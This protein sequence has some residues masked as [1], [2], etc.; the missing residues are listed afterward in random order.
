MSV[1]SEQ[2]IDK[3]YTLITQD[4]LISRL[5]ASNI[6][7]VVTSAM[8]TV[9]EYKNLH[10]QEKKQLVLVVLKKVI[11]KQVSDKTTKKQLLSLL[12]T[13]I[14]SVIDNFI[15][16]ARGNTHDALAKPVSV[17]VVKPTFDHLYSTVSKMVKGRTVTPTNI[18]TIGTSVM[19]LVQTY[20]SLN[21]P[22]KKQ[23]VIDILLTLVQD[24]TLNLVPDEHHKQVLHV[25][26]SVLPTAIDMTV[27]FAKGSLYPFFKR[28]K[29]H[30]YN[31][32]GK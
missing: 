24:D 31:C 20:P 26:E 32:I 10:G 30:W 28:I 16:S 8:K 22:E 14:P 29:Q 5:N 21:G 3:L 15:N 4:I 13:T 18:V 19:A 9:Q 2:I 12:D 23:L 27:S 11:T 1:Q 25:I 17:S 7:I 6:L